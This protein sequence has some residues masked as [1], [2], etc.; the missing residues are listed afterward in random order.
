VSH[1]TGKEVL[2]REF[3]FRKYVRRWVP[4]WLDDAQKNH[5]R[6][7]A[8]ELLELLRGR[9]A[10]DF[11]WIAVSDDSRFRYHH[12]PH[13][14]FTALR[15]KVISFARTQRG[16]QKVMVTVFFTSTALT[17]SEALLKGKKFN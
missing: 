1:S 17:V 12:E 4:H 16:V 13:K 6:P 15:E 9:E 8:I 5:R 14:I 3:G 2:R 7:S 10:D 11:V